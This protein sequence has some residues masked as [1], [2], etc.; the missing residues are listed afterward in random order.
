MSNLN[1]RPGD[2]LENSACKILLLTSSNSDGYNI[3]NYVP[4][5]SEKCVKSPYA[6][7]E[8]LYI[9]YA[10]LSYIPFNPSF[11][12]VGRVSKD[13]LDT[14]KSRIS[15]YFNISCE[16]ENKPIAATPFEESIDKM[17]S[18]CRD[19]L[20][21]KNANY[22][23]DA[24]PTGNFKRAAALQNITDKQAL[25]GMMDKHVVS[26][27][28]LVLREANG[29]KIFGSTWEEKIGDNINYLLILYAMTKMED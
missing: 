10:R 23:T 4:I 11:K 18:Y 25:L 15:T 29:E 9:E 24:D 7:L 5:T 26:I 3:I 13:T 2:I 12:V 17:I 14:V 27:H 1:L 22:N 20:F 28:D 8:G 21:K 19:L 16:N 6:Y